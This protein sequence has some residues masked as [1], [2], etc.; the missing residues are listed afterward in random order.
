MSD[1]AT[2]GGAPARHILGPA[3]ADHLGDAIIALTRELWVVTD[4]ML[5]MERMLTEQGM[6]LSGLDRY[7]PDAALAATLAARRSALLAHVTAALGVEDAG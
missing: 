3:Q 2:S 6:D 7:Q 1:A 5:V 4:R